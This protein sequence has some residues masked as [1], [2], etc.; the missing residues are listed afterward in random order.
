VKAEVFGYGLSA[1]CVAA[2]RGLL[3]EQA[4][5]VIGVIGNAIFRLFSM[6]KYPA[7]SPASLARL[8]LSIPSMWRSGLSVFNA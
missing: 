7:S 3:C 1:G 5:G 6:L 2:R 4:I 8:S